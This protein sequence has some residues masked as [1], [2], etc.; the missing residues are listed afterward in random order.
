[1]KLLEVL[2]TLRRDN[3]DIVRQA[4]QA[5]EGL[6][7]QAIVMDVMRMRQMTDEMSQHAAFVPCLGKLNTLDGDEP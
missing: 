2:E 6:K 3:L 4:G 5:M 1:L 7:Q